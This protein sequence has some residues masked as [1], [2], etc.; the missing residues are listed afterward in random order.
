MA[1]G[2]VEIVRR[3]YEAFH[4]GDVEGSLAFFHPEVVAD[5]TR[6]IDGELGRGREELAGIIGGW[7]GAFE[8]WREEIEE[9]RDLGDQVY[10]VAKQR[11]RGRSSG[12]ETELRY[13]LLYEVREGAITRMTLYSEPAEALEAAGAPGD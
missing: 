2:N 8:E 3:M 6:R 12:I 10:V 7:V 4:G 5:V 13:A 1:R 9:I 11:G